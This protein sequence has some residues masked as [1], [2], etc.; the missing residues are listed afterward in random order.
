[1]TKNTQG[2]G[3]GAVFFLR[4]LCDDS[5][6]QIKVLFHFLLFLRN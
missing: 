2:S 6:E 4:T 3:A 5:V 1:M